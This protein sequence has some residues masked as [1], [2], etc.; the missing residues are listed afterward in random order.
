MMM[1]KFSPV[2][3]TIVYSTIVA[4]VVFVVFVN[5]LKLDSSEAEENVVIASIFSIVGVF[6]YLYLTKRRI[7]I[8]G[9]I[10][11][12]LFIDFFLFFGLMVLAFVTGLLEL[13]MPIG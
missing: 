11:S 8:T 1:E 10:V 5:L 7:S 2:T 13:E 12:L 6:S 3:K 9:R 4:I